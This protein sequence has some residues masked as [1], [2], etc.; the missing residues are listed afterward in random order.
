MTKP[1]VG[2]AVQMLID[3]G[4]LSLT[5]R[6]SKYLPSFDND[7][8]RSIF[9]EQLLTHSAGFPLTR[10]NKQLT[11]YGGQR[12]VAESGWPTWSRWPAREIPLQRLRSETLAAIV[13]AISGEPADAFIRRHILEPLG[14]KDTY[15]VL[16][17]RSPPTGRASARITRASPGMWHKYW[18][19]GDKPFFPFFLGAASGY[20]TALDYAKFLGL[21]LSRGQVDGKRLLSQAAIDRALKPAF[22]M[23][24]P[25]TSLPYP[26]GLKAATALLWST[27]DDLSGPNSTR[28]LGP[29][30]FLDMEDRMARWRWCFLSKS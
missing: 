24:S 20:S 10:I 14:M 18:D 11:A 29:C 1:L 26:T 30:P 3:Q 23:L 13:A 8:S 9:V 21:W 5:D 16:E 27:L 28:R 19:H 6:A 25:G 12:E 2:T 7:K 22:A 17:D 15:C 4:K